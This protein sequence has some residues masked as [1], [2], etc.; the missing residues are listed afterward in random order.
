MQSKRISP[1]TI[2]LGGITLAVLVVLTY[3]LVGLFRADRI[4]TSPTTNANANA[5]GGASANDP[6]AS[7]ARP[8]GGARKPVTYSNIYR[9]DYVGPEA[10]GKCHAKNYESW[11]LHP[12]S[13]MNASPLATSVV[14]NFGDERLA[15]DDGHVVFTKQDGEFVMR[16]FRKDKFVRALKVTRTVGSRLTQMYIGVQSEGAEPPD[17]PVWRDEVKLPFA[18]WIQRKT[19]FPDTFNEQ[20][21]PS[22]Y[23]EQGVLNEHY[24]FYRKPQLPWNRVCIKCHNTYPYATRFEISKGKHLV[25]F[26]ASDID[27]DKPVLARGGE[28][29]PP[30]LETRDL[31]T[32]G[33]S[34]ETCHFGG[35][36][37]A[38]N[39]AAI[40]FLPRG[41]GLDF[42]KATDDL[43]ARARQSNYVINGICKQCHTT[44]LE[45]NYPNGGGSWNSR[46]ASD[47]LAGACASQIACTNCHN[48]HQAGPVPSGQD[49]PSQLASCTSCHDKYRAREA[50]AAHAGH[51]AN[52][53][54]NCLDCHMPRIVHGVGNMVR[55]HRISSPTDARMIEGGFPNACNM[56]HL[57]KSI[58]W[59]LESL[60]TKWN[61]KV[62]LAATF[63]P[64][65]EPVGEA[66]LKHKDAIVR[67]VAVD[68]YSRSADPKRHA[69]KILPILVDPVPQNRFFG[70]L[71]AERA[72]GRPLAV[73][74][75]AAWASKAERE[76][77][78]QKLRN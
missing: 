60:A 52:V 37:H 44:D 41:A 11:K 42:P 28:R 55:T 47:L 57:D 27:L 4:V 46:E 29:G 56:C 50:S 53:E 26:P 71:A 78:V 77:Q 68:A 34:C 69:D 76:R 24:A 54:V 51:P 10:C 13:R 40:S 49:Q 5:D 66:W 59:T 19:W 67:Q 48:P 17:D 36:E 8:D 14:G 20:Q 3:Q 35:R 12:H 65:D 64:S 39:G 9:P 33:I 43:I 74:E 21:P 15:Y 23:D 61:K 75:Y 16:I 45:G 58:R 63:Q 30:L 2:A 32:L 62:P 18:W 72:L 1:K 22:E 70:V 7:A 31:V 6:N 73:T 38:L 25:G